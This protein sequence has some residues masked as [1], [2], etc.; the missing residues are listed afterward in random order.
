MKNVILLHGTGD[1]PKLFWFPEIAKQLMKKGFLV[2]APQLPNAMKPSL[3]DWLPFVLE[4]GKFSR[5][6]ILIG[7]SAG[8]QLILSLLENIPVKV[9][10]AILVSGYAES[11]PEISG[12][13]N[14]RKFLWGKIRKHAGNFV[15]INSDNDPWGC[16]DKQGRIMLNRLG[17]TLIIPRG[18]GHMGSTTYKQP[19][20]K[21]PLLLSF[22]L[23]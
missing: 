20:K 23:T 18:E 11:L 6:T 15:F 22:V 13:K 10:Q 9:K 16:N 12:A 14:R 4:N 5:G 2:W 21:F 7:H 3:K 17:G 8:A 19:Y 1:S